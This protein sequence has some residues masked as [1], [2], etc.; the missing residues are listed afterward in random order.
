MSLIRFL[1]DSDPAILKDADDGCYSA[2]A[3]PDRATG[4]GRKFIKTESCRKTSDARRY[5]LTDG[6]SRCDALAPRTLGQAACSSCS[7]R[8]Y[9]RAALR[10][11]CEQN[12]SVRIACSV[13]SHRLDILV[14]DKSTAGRSI[15][16]AVSTVSGVR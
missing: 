6:H 5:R 8:A 2:L 11:V 12:A 15:E 10:R 4:R 16:Q 14:E 1:P 3:L 7:D 9:D 13:T